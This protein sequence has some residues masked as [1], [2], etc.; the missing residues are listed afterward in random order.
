MATLLRDPHF[1]VDWLGCE[2]RPVIAPWHCQ[3]PVSVGLRRIG[4]AGIVAFARG[5]T[6]APRLRRVGDY[7]IA[8][9]VCGS[10]V[11]VP[12]LIGLVWAR[13]CTC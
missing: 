9:R 3:P 5:S 4:D 6:M 1:A 13:G 12:P 2:S 10:E 7:E 11:R 8:H